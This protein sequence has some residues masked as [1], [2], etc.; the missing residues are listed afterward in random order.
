MPKCVL[1][2]RPLICKSFLDLLYQTTHYRYPEETT[3]ASSVFLLLFS[4]QIALV[5]QQAMLRK[6]GLLT[7]D[8]LHKLTCD[9]LFTP[10]VRPLCRNQLPPVNQFFRSF[11]YLDS[12]I[13]SGH[14]GHTKGPYQKRRHFR[15]YHSAARQCRHCCKDDEL[16]QWEMPFFGADSSET[17]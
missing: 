7:F 2:L 13:E 3:F 12:V 4:Y 9:F 11:I 15:R 10:V 14:C 5:L 1:L 17:L 8:T 16:F 6:Q